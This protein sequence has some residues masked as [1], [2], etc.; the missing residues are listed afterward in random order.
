MNNI[1]FLKK[2]K[3]KSQDS[4]KIMETNYVLVSYQPTLLLFSLRK[5]Y[6]SSLRI[7]SFLL[8]RDR[9]EAGAGLEIRVGLETKFNTN[10]ILSSSP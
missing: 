8:S 4:K 9:S 1:W 7:Y 5:N 3:K 6:S 10:R 2:K